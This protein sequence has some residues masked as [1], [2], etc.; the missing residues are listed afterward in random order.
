LLGNRT[1]IV[2]IQYEARMITLATGEA[3][4]N[5]E[6][7]VC[8]LDYKFYPASASKVDPRRGYKLEIAGSK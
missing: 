4:T 2:V 8:S 3:T 1:E 5:R 6:N 7:Y